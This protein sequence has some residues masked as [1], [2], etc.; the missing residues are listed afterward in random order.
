MSVLFIGK[1]CSYLHN[2]IQCGCDISIAPF[3]TAMLS[4]VF[5]RETEKSQTNFHIGIERFKNPAYLG[6]MLFLG[7]GASVLCFVT[8]NIAVRVLGAIKTSISA[9]GVLFTLSGLLFSERKGKGQQ[10]YE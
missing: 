9:V 7:I 8:W 4:R 10:I 6:N 1:C 2:G 5:L 3:F